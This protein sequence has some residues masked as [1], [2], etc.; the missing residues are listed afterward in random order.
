MHSNTNLILNSDGKTKLRRMLL[1]LISTIQ[2]LS[3]LSSHL[4]GIVVS[5]VVNDSTIE[6]PNTGRRPKNF[7][8]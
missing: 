1:N 4:N 5:L 2:Q 6:I 3:L 8:K 7:D